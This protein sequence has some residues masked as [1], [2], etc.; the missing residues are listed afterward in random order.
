M[1]LSASKSSLESAIRSAFNNINRAGAQDGS[2]PEAN[3]SE[4]ASALAS[5]IHSYVTSAE[6]DITPVTTTVLPGIP[7][8]P[9]PSIPATTAPGPTTHT[10]FGKLV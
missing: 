10:G 4:L 1:S 8:A 7:V 9:P 5:A 2:N 3:I 6:V